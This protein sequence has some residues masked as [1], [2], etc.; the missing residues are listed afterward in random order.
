MRNPSQLRIFCAQKL[1]TSQEMEVY[2][3][4]KRKKHPKLPNGYGSIKYLG[5][6]RRN[7]YGVYPPAREI[8]EHGSPITPPAICYVDDW[9]KGFIVLTAYKAGNYKP[10][11]ELALNLDDS[12][13]DNLDS[14]ARR[15]MA[16]Y[17]QATRRNL[18]GKTFADVYHDFYNDKYVTHAKKEY[19]ESSKRNT[20]AS[21]S[22]CK[23]IHNRDFSG[24]R[25]A[26]LQAVVDNS[27]LKNAGQEMLVTTL[28]QIYRYALKVE[29]ID[30]DHSQFVTVTAQDADEHGVPFSD[31]EL[32]ILWANKEDPTVEFLLIM[33]YTGFRITAYRTIEVNL[34]EW[35]LKGGVK[36]ESSKG[37]IVP[38][39]TGI[40]DLVKRRMKRDGN[41]LSVHNNTFRLQMH[42]SMDRLGLDRHTPHDCRHTFSRLAEKYCIRENDRKRL[43]GHAFD[44]ITNKVYGHRELEDLRAEVEKIEIPEKWRV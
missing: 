7:P 37:R 13:G 26:D 43:L 40:R 34:S 31:D 19:S 36:T 44:D 20:S 27:G 42:K 18:L 30:K 3:M 8:N 22:K 12:D 23:P 32:E 24:I 1:A 9:M 10:G 5:K 21:F 14:L 16:D 4:A 17:G 2:H 6:G 38:I 28:H 39:H 41:L 33:C 35:Y 29:L 11:D 15:I 25:H